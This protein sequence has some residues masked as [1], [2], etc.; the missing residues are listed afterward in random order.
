MLFPPFFPIGPFLDLEAKA[1]AVTDPDNDE[2]K[3]AVG[4]PSLGGGVGWEGLVCDD[5]DVC[6]ETE[7]RESNCWDSDRMRR[8][9]V[10]SFIVNRSSSSHSGCWPPLYRQLIPFL[11]P[12]ESACFQV[13]C[14][15]SLLPT[16]S[17]FQLLLARM[18][19]E[20]HTA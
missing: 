18:Q 7:D 5:N 11:L 10:S 6:L 14:F 3:E 8:S 1:W 13:R 12:P 15:Q 20:G 19:R 2:F 9:S 16:T 17:S 4:V